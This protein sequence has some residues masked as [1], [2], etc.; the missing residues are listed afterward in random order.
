MG[1]DT[2]WE[3]D[4]HNVELDGERSYVNSM[5]MPFSLVFLEQLINSFCFIEVVINGDRLSLNVMIFEFEVDQWC[6]NLQH[7]GKGPSYDAILETP[8]KDDE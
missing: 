5:T 4:A 3:K 7:S 8:T 1:L 2:S 6:H